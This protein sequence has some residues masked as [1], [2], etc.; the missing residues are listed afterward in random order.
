MKQNAILKRIKKKEKKT[1]QNW[2]HS[3]FYNM[4]EYEGVFIGYL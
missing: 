2:L 1:L 4:P 3:M